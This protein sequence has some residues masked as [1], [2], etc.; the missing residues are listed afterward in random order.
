MAHVAGVPVIA[1]EV[2]PLGRAISTGILNPLDMVI[3]ADIP[4]RKRLES[5]SLHA[6]MMEAVG[7]PAGQLLE[8]PSTALALLGRVRE[9]L[10]GGD[11][12]ENP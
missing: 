5:Q 2:S 8:K 9:A 10:G 11:P 12:V 7:R 6:Q 4:E 1:H 3:L